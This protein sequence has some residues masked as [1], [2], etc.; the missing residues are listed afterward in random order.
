MEGSQ[1][2]T[3]AKKGTSENVEPGR[4]TFSAPVNL[5]LMGSHRSFSLQFHRLFRKQ[6]FDVALHALIVSTHLLCL[7]E[8]SPKASLLTLPANQ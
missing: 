6:R 5:T 3:W 7:F 4:K 1:V 2:G 8:Q